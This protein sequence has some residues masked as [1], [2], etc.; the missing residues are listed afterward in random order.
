AHT[1]P[2]GSSFPPATGP[3]SLLHKLLG[4]PILYLRTILPIRGAPITGQPRTAQ[5]R[6]HWRP[7]S[8][9]TYANRVPS[10]R[11]VQSAFSPRVSLRLGPQRNLSQ[12]SF[13][14]VCDLLPI[15]VP[16]PILLTAV[17]DAA[18]GLCITVRRRQCQTPP[19]RIEGVSSALRFLV[20]DYV[21]VP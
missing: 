20:T 11:P 16:N 10:G 21:R 7:A 2:S 15:L 18:K 17:V 6:A 5:R 9:Q 8:E 4:H 1:F 19:L 3:F 12:P 13:S 14:R